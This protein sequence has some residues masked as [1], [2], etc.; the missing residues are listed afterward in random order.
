MKQ[1]TAR[2]IVLLTLI[3][4]GI[5]AVVAALLGLVTQITADK[6]SAITAE[7]TANAMAQVLSAENYT[8]ITDYEDATGLVD[9][10]YLADDKGYVLQ[11]TVSG[12][13]GMITLMV[14]V[15]CDGAVTGISIID[16]GETPGL[17]A[18]YAQDS[19]KGNAFR[20]SLV[21]LQGTVTTEDVDYI[22][23]ATVTANA[24]CTAVSAATAC[25]AA[26]VG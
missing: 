23:G 21:G 18:V 6:I 14:G 25:V 19:A 8:E 26:Y 4:L 22:S 13:Q 2:Y 24:I 9:N 11:T 7:K 10:M 17:G 3:L 15:D 1:G 16:H 20:D 12:S 5:T